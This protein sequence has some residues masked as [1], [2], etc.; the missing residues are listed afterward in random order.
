[1]SPIRPLVLRTVANHLL[2]VTD[3]RKVSKASNVYSYGVLF[4]LLTRK[5]PVHAMGSDEV[6]VI[7]LV[8]WVHSF[9]PKMIE[10]AKMVED[11]RSV[12]TGNS[13]HMKQSLQVRPQI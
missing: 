2:E 4:E 7:N 12:N 6:E 9:R 10:V 1:M 3:T 5:S 8:Q 13:H 11:I